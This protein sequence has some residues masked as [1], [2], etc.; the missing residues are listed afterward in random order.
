M[1]AP[2]RGSV[3]FQTATQARVLVSTGWHIGG[4]WQ[5]LAGQRTM[6]ILHL[7][8]LAEGEV[9]LRW[10]R[11]EAWRF[12]VGAG[13]DAGRLHGTAEAGVPEAACRNAG[14]VR[15]RKLCSLLL[16]SPLKVLLVL[17]GLRVARWGCF[18]EY[19]LQQWRVLPRTVPTARRVAP[20]IPAVGGPGLGLLR[21]V[22]HLHYANEATHAEVGLPELI[23]VAEAPGVILTY[24]VPHQGAPHHPRSSSSL[25]EAIL[26]AVVVRTVAGVDLV[27]HPR[28]VSSLAEIVLDPDE[29]VVGQ[30][31][32]RSVSLSHR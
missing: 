21:N 6:A 18:I 5:R 24:Q 23:C 26:I 28:Q 19:L 7:I 8:R 13:Q 12:A 30:V 32:N 11:G 1:R 3:A 22:Q 10:P 16:C 4:I 20:S 15:L 2:K 31:A 17:H 29:N 27:G 25:E 9:Q 14:P